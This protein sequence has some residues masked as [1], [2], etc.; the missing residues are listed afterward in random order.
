[1]KESVKK[2]YDELFINYPA[3]EI[4]NK[5]VLR[6]Y[7]ILEATYKNGGKILVCGNGGSAADCEHI[8]GELMKGFKLQRKLGDD[9]ISFFSQYESGEVIAKTLQKGLPAISLVSHTGLMS[10][11]MNDCDAD[12]VFAQ[13]VYGYM[14]GNDTLIALST[15]G[16]SENV[17]RAAV[18]AKVKGGKVVAFTGEKGGKL[19]PLSDAI[20]RLPSSDTAKIQEFTLPLYHC[21][22]A[23]LE[24]EF[25]GE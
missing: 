19:L 1:M 17:C 21:L 7:E 4:C 8:V 22:C 16:N 20:V 10:A 9:E 23:M 5:S 12:S 6:A 2:I 18:T 13:Q 3:L 14:N 15:S 11:F 25:F 24:E